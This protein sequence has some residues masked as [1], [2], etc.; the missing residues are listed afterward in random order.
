[1]SKTYP[2]TPYLNHCDWERLLFLG[3]KILLA[4][5]KKKNKTKKK[6]VVLIAPASAD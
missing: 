6:H 4:K 5:K 1:M 2:T 3:K